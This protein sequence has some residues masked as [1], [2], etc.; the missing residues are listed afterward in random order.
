MSAGEVKRLLQGRVAV[1]TGGGGE[2]GGAIARRFVAEGAAV[3]VADIRGESAERAAED[4]RNSGGQARAIQANVSVPVQAQQ[5]V[6]CAVEAFG[7]L[8]TLVN[9]AAA[10]TPDGTVETLTVEQ[11]NEALAV[12]LTGAFL[13]CKYAV[14]EIRKAG[15]GTIVNIASQLGQIGV[16]GRA[17]YSTSKA[18]LIQFTK[19]LAVDHAQ[20]GIRVNS[21]SPGGVDTARTV[22]RFGS[23]EAAN[24]ARGPYH[25]LGRTG[26]VEE[27]AAGALFLASEESSFM[28]GADLL[29]DG[30]YLAFKSVLPKQG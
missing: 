7:T 17:P 20:D 10:V 27:I 8:T 9:V 5:A 13:T 6:Q 2:I 4:I 3:V 26:R 28:T 30:G 11:W 14:P 29:L 24:Q 12:N 16:A 18:A 19:C 21:L 15:G 23:R 1:V 22:R 25:L